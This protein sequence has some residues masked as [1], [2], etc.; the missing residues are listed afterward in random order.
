MLMR[1]RS[2]VAAAALFAGVVLALPAPSAAQTAGGDFDGHLFIVGGG[3]RPD[4][5]MERFIELAGGP[6]IARI[7]VFPTAS[8]TPERTGDAL[9]ASLLEL[10]AAEAFN[11]PLTREEALAGVGLDRLAG[12]TGVWFVGG[13]QTRITAAFLDTPIAEA[14]HRLLRDGAVIGGTSAGAAMQSATM[15]PGGERRPGGDRPSD[16]SYITIERDNVRT[17]P[18]LGF[19]ENTIIDQHFI[20]RKRNNRLISAVLDN[21]HLLGAGIDES[22]AI[23]VNP[24]GTWE[25]VGESVVMI[26]DARGSRITGAS[27]NVLGAAALHLHI[28][29]EGS[30]FDPATGEAR[31]PPSDR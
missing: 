12:V 20:R 13:S 29:P 9:A 2:I 17:E 22:T 10:G 8:T 28:L 1:V 23:Q 11:L 30:V 5:M 21:P 18:G 27:A 4:A 15:I 6:G 31:L 7:A 26:Y 19:L 14:L 24:D 25:I 16:D 3:P